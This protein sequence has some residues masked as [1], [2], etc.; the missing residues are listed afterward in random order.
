MQQQVNVTARITFSADAELDRAELLELARADLA[1]LLDPDEGARGKLEAASVALLELQEEAAIY[2]NTPGR[3][4]ELEQLARECMDCSS[5]SVADRHRRA[6]ACAREA[7]YSARQGLELRSIFQSSAEARELLAAVE[8]T[9]GPISTAERL[10]VA[11]MIAA[12]AD[13]EALALGGSP[14]LL[15]AG[16]ALAEALEL[17]LETHI[18]EPGEV[19]ADSGELIAINDWRQARGQ[20]P[21]E[22]ETAAEEEI[23]AA[24]EPA[25]RVSI[26]NPA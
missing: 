22:L 1:R 20:A 19:P 7:A 13:G 3:L 2:G 14:E 25:L 17:T 8:L 12:R 23:E 26:S 6:G 21:L 24:Q 16:D 10:L 18:Y 9:A 5:P 11:A 15:A 4:G